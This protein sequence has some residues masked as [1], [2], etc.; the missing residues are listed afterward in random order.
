MS[1][2]GVKEL[3]RLAPGFRR[4]A[5][6][7]AVAGVL[8]WHAG[9]PMLVTSSPRFNEMSMVFLVGVAFFW[10]VFQLL[11]L[12]RWWTVT[13]AG[14]LLLAMTVVFPVVLLGRSQAIGGTEHAQQV[15]APDGSWV[16]VYTIRG[17]EAEDTD[18]LVRQER[19]LPGGFR[20]VR[21][22]ARFPG[23]AGVSLKVSAGEVE[24][25]VAE[26]GAHTYELRRHVYF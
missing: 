22:V 2:T 5:L 1:F 23:C 7:A 25:V 21:A 16:R 20:L 19:D 6:L 18:V 8:G 9:H 14:V 15:A 26:S 24:V 10:A 12:R 17:A 3:P 13:L 11:V 4:L